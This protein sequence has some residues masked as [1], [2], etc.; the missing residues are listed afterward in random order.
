MITNHRPR[1][2]S[3]SQ[4]LARFGF[5]I[6]A[7][8]AVAAIAVVNLAIY[9]VISS[10]TG[11]FYVMP[12]AVAAIPLFVALSAIPAV[13][14][15]ILM[16]FWFRLSPWR[17]VACLLGYSALSG[18]VSVGVTAWCVM[19]AGPPVGVVAMASGGAVVGLL[20]GCADIFMEG[21]KKKSE[22][23]VLRTYP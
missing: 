1:V 21:R 10:G 6:F 5:H 11:A 18:A 2:N 22:P 8:M 4:F 14:H 17:G 23:P 13:L 19:L 9:V 7:M 12:I 20:L 15:A 3:S 16:E